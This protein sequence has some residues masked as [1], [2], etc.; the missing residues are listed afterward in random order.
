[1]A[2]ICRHS[3]LRLGLW[4]E[5]ATPLKYAIFL[6]SA[7]DARILEKDGGFRHQNLQAYL[8]QMEEVDWK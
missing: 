7:T 8:A 6:N 2:P 1:M 5:G 4:L 3:I